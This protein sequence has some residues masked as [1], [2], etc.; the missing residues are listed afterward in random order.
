MGLQN[1]LIVTLR[2]SKTPCNKCPD[3]GTKQSDGQAS[4]M[5]PSQL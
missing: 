5:L 3:D 4:V 2:K 1:T